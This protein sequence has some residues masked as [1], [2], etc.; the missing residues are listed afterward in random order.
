MKSW[1][2]GLI[3]AGLVAT[4]GSAL[5]CPTGNGEFQR[6]TRPVQSASFQ[7]SE[8]IERAD[9]L[10]SVAASHEQSAKAF[11]REA[12]TLT[13]RARLLRRQA[14]SVGAADR[15]SLLA[16][17]DEL[18]LRAEGDKARAASERAR[19]SELRVEARGLRDRALRLVRFGGGGNVVDNG[20]RSRGRPIGDPRPLP[21]SGRT[22]I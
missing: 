9:G 11:D 20:W 22:A 2:V 14:S 12:S 16:I 1:V 15:S 19:A 3:A 17:A 8:L 4:G 10:E 18:T 7:A 5:A 6:P 21:P 13:N